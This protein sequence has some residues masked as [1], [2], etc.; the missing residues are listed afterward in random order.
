MSADE[1]VCGE[2]FDH[3]F[4]EAEFIDGSA[5]LICRNCGGEIFIDEE[6]ES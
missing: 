3:D 4:P 6:D 1:W 5:V 2:S